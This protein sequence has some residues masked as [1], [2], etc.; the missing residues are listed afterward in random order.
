MTDI[1]ARCTGGAKLPS[2]KA[3]IHTGVTVILP[4]GIKSTQL[5]PCY[6]A[7]HD[8]NGMSELTGSHALHEYG[9]LNIVSYFSSKAL[10]ILSAWL[11]TINFSEVSEF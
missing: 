10:H 9:Y 1:F 3:D 2:T 4:R 5:K 6:A 11:A 7:T 8:L